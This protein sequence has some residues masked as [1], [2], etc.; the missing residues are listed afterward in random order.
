MKRVLVGMSGGVDSAVAAY[1]L[2]KEGYEVCGVTLRTWAPDDGS[3]GRC[4]E[5]DDA[6]RISNTLGIRFYPLNCLEDFSRKVV[7]PFVESYLAG[8]TPNPC[9]ECNRYLKWDKILYAAKVMEAD[10]VATGHYAHVLKLDN[11]RYTVKKADHAAKD[12]TYMLYKLTQEQ[13]AATL[14]PLGKY[15]KAQVRR[16]AEEAGLPVANKPDSQ[17]ICFV[18]DG[19]YAD[20]IEDYAEKKN[21]QSLS[22]TSGQASGVRIMT[23]PGPGNFVDEDGNV[24]GKHKGITHYTIGQRKGLGIAMGRPIYVKEIRADSNEV[25]LSDEPALFSKVVLVRDV[26][27]LSIPGMAPGEQLRARAK[28]RYHHEAAPA[29][30]EM[31]EDGCIRIT[32]DQPVRAAAPGQ[33]SVFYD[34]NDCVIGGGIIC[35]PDMPVHLS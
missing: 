19:H 8:E 3:E 23:V 27:F 20:F 30:L 11:G 17:E 35:L 5:I 2:Q 22:E 6:R 21:A 26:N 12:Q 28:V 31:Q 15:T 14:M 24:L 4:C 16:I 34:D 18:T 32:F 7:D 13:L 25:V 9:I 1:L 10:Y 33:S 29:V